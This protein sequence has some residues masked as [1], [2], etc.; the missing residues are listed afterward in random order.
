MTEGNE[1]ADACA[2]A[3]ASAESPAPNG[4]PGSDRPPGSAAATAGG[5]S[6]RRA[7]GSVRKLAGVVA[8]AAAGRQ[9]ALR[10]VGTDRAVTPGDARSGEADPVPPGER[11]HRSLLDHSP[12]HVG[13][14]GALGAMVAFGLVNVVLSLQQILV[15]VVLAL[16]L[17]LGIN[18]VVE[19]LVSRRLPRGLAVLVVTVVLLAMLVLGGWAVFP[20][21][22][23]QVTNLIRNAP[24]YLQTLRENPQ[25]AGFDQ[26]YNVIGKITGFLTSGDWIN[27]MF[28]G[29]VG[30]GRLLAN[31]VFSLIMTIVLTVYFLASLPTIKNVIYQMAPA[32]RRKRVHF[33]ANEMFNRIGGYLTGMFAVVTLWGIGSFIVM[34][35]VGLGQYSVALCFVVAAFAFIPVVGS[36][37]A[38]GIICTI[39]LSVSPQAAL[40]CAIYFLA[41]S[42]M[43]AY[44][45]QPRIFSKSLNVPPALV[46]LGAISGGIL[47]GIVGALLAIPTVASLILLW[48]EVFV[49]SLDSA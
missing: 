47:L 6:S 11:R 28:G 29:L 48:R 9:A 30:A 1:A 4:V 8:R 19:A 20:V 45:V 43:D 31:T 41:Y 24:G 34:N 32:S 39:A 3:V 42:Q 21:I 14:V 13:F 49:P 36:F 40:A 15:L 38:M 18:P 10:R 44:L 26:Q 23:D 37:I 12:F 33:L 27:A 5:E 22:N 2:E 17:A 46:I 25:I 7:N 16:F 35:A